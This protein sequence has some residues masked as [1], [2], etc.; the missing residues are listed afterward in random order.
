MTK[1]TYL[2]HEKWK[3]YGYRHSYYSSYKEGHRRGVATLISN[4]IQF[5][6]DKEIRDKEGR[7]I[8]VRGRIEN[9]P[10]TLINVYAPPESDTYLKKSLFDIIAAESEGILIC[11]HGRRQDFFCCSSLAVAIWQHGFTS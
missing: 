3:R 8:I 10:I 9:E 11:G 7:Y 6:Y 1:L 2:E 4:K 5:D